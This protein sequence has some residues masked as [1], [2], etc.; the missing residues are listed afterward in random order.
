MKQL[1]KLVLVTFIFAGC[2]ND[3]DQKSTTPTD[4]LAQSIDSTKID[5]AI[6]A[7]NLPHL[8][9]RD[10]LI[11]L[12]SSNEEDFAVN[13]YLTERLQP[14]RKNFKRINSITKWTSTNT[15]E[16]WES[17]EGGEATFYYNNETLEKISTRHFGEMSQQLSEYYLMNGQLSFV[18]EKT[19]QYNRPLFY[20]S[21]AMKANKDTEAFDFE[22]SEIIEDRSYFEKGKLI[23][24]LNNQDCGSPF[25]AD[26]LLEEQKRIKTYFEKLLKLGK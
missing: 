24:Q 12:E 14:I 17:T 22:K 10:T 23:H 11:L 5:T 15:K 19:F 2:S 4:T 3:T 25:A 26:Y 21:V 9:P 16:L 6:S 13:E 18:F 1:S 20:D 8:P 7:K